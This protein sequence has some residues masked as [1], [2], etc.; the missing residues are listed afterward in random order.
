MKKQLFFDDNKLF[1]KENVIRKDVKEGQRFYERVAK[2]AS[3]WCKEDGLL[4][5]YHLFS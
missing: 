2:R 3:V 1:S 4:K 5:R